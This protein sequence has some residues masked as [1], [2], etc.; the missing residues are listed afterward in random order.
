L[1]PGDV[2]AEPSLRIG[3]VDEDLLQQL[4]G[5]AAY[6]WIVAIVK[7]DL[8][9]GLTAGARQLDADQVFG[10]HVIEVFP[11]GSPSDHLITPFIT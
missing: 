11:V 10:A 7:G 5:A 9:H 4:H 1:S 8:G 6:A 2:G 3:P